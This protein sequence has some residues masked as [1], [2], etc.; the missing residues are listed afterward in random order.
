MTLRPPNSVDRVFD[1]R[2]IDESD[3]LA[4]VADADF[5]RRRLFK[6]IRRNA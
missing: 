3:R 4:V 2:G 6:T 5:V 1:R